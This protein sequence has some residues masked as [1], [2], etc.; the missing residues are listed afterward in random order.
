MNK[1][2]PILLTGKHGTGKTT[3]AR[4]NYQMQ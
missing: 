2:R 1:N 4:E 3:Q